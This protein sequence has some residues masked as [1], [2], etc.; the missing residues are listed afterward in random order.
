[1][2][3]WSRHAFLKTPQK[4]PASR[5]AGKRSAWRFHC[6]A[7]ATPPSSTAWQRLGP[8]WRTRAEPRLGLTTVS[9]ALTGSHR[10]MTRVPLRS[11]TRVPLRPQPPAIESPATLR[12]RCSQAS[13]PRCTPAGAEASPWPPHVR[14]D[15]GV[16]PTT[17]RAGNGHRCRGTRL[18]QTVQALRGGGNE[19]RV[20]RPL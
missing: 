9:A 1:M 3:I 6:H 11:M 5:P 14:T 4:V 16:G 17:R 12:A 10:A 7:P 2:Q 19:W 15:P 8:P 18:R 20:P 13:L